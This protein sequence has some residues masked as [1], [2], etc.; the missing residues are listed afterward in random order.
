MLTGT[1]NLIA[2]AVS[3]YELEGIN[4]VFDAHSTDVIWNGAECPLFTLDQVKTFF[5][6][7]NNDDD[8][9]AKVL[10]GVALISIESSGE[11]VRI[12]ARDGYFEI[13]GWCFI[14]V[15]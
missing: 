11:E 14:S 9:D 12:E 10:D 5:D 4:G 2:G 13:A 15:A 6:V 3:T 1:N 7:L 8:F